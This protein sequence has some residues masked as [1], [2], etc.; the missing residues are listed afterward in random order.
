M[1]MVDSGND[2]SS[3]GRMRR[4]NSR[5]FETMTP[6]PYNFVP[7]CATV[8]LG[9]GK[10]ILSH[11]GNQ[12]F[13]EIVSTR[14]NAY[15]DAESRLD[16]TAIL[17]D[18]IEQV[19]QNNPGGGFVKQNP[20]TGQ[21]FEV[22]DFLAKE[23]TAQAFRDALH[24]YYSS[25]NPSK[26]KRRVE[27]STTNADDKSEHSQEETQALKPASQ[28][29]DQTL[30]QAMHRTFSFRR[31]KSAPSSPTYSATTPD[32]HRS[33]TPPPSFSRL[34]SQDNCIQQENHESFSSK[35][36]RQSSVLYL[37][38][39]AELSSAFEAVDDACL[40]PFEPIPLDMCDEVDL[41]KL[42]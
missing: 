23:K 30:I 7:T 14:L 4:I 29:S 31:S 34:I 25:S 3:S 41:P 36:K 1:S 27:E 12:L 42:S 16:K 35:R 8:L 21:Y 40:D 18:V 15:L 24:E 20:K 26:R 2:S 9:R 10:K 37:G 17:M 22:G 32:F 5:G 28:I 11:P 39:L 13:K 33:A 6:L 38:D 19:R